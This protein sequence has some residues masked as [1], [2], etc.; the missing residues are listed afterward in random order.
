MGDTDVAAGRRKRVHADANAGLVQSDVGDEACL[1]DVHVGGLALGPSREDDGEGVECRVVVPILAHHG[2]V[3]GLAGRGDG[4]GGTAGVGFGLQLVP[5]L[6]EHEVG[7]A[8]T[9]AVGNAAQLGEHIGAVLLDEAEAA[10]SDGHGSLPRD[11][12]RLV[13]AFEGDLVK[14]TDLVAGG[15]SELLAHIERGAADFDFAV[16]GSGHKRSCVSE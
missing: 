12:H 10:V 9:G 13:D 8:D 5:D 4:E 7:E 16:A 6:K 1:G 11:R 2:V 15:L 14:A 3:I